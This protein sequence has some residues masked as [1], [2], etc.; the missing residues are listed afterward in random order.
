MSQP[1]P[2]ATPVFDLIGVGFGPSN[3]AMAIATREHNNA[4]PRAAAV[5]AH[6]LERQPQFGWHRGMLIDDATMRFC[7]LNSKNAR[8]KLIFVRARVT[9]LFRAGAC[10]TRRAA[11]ACCAR[12]SLLCAHRCVRALADSAV[13]RRCHLCPPRITADAVWRAAH[14]T[15]AAAVLCA[16]DCNARARVQR[17][18]DAV[19]GEGAC[20]WTVRSAVCVRVCVCVYS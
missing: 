5:T 6:F 16:H 3:L 2:S 11:V 14:T 9:S 12:C 4:V 8:R 17:C 15:R 20:L 10:D 1:L 19:G 18:A 7:F 13:A